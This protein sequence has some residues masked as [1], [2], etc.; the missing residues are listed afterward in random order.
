[1]KGGEAT[2]PAET[3]IEFT[4]GDAAGYPDPVL[5][6]SG[7]T[8]FRITYTN[9]KDNRDFVSFVCYANFTE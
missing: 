6:V 3:Y 8:I 7:E 9:A 4:A 1:L 2:N 5:P